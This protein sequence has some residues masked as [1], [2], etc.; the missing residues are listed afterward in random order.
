MNFKKI[1][2]WGFSWDSDMDR[3]ELL[4]LLA[5]PRDSFPCIW[6]VGWPVAIDVAWNQ[7]QHI[8]IS[9]ICFHL[10]MKD[11]GKQVLCRKVLGKSQRKRRTEDFAVKDYRKYTE[12]LGWRRGR[13]TNLCL[14]T[15]FASLTVYRTSF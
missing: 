9:I 15:S 1:K 6:L 14:P 7:P 2:F 3:G 4:K 5:V 8:S 11:M 10:F 12:R 13:D